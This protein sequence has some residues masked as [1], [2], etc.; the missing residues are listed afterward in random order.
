MPTQ[1]LARRLANTHSQHA[2]DTQAASA[3]FPA[4]T[5]NTELWTRTREHIALSNMPGW[6]ST[7]LAHAV[8]H[9]K[10]KPVLRNKGLGNY[11]LAKKAAA[12]FRDGPSAQQLQTSRDPGRG[13]FNWLVFEALGFQPGPTTNRQNHSS[14]NASFRAACVALTTLLETPRIKQLITRQLR[15]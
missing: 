11:Q 1:A 9:A 12:I 8:A 5:L 7:H 14:P 3:K 4:R 10:V 13:F 15:V 2:H 6:T